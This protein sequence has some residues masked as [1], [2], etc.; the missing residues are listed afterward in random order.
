MLF[1]LNSRGNFPCQAHWFGIP[2]SNT[3][4]S[5]VHSGIERNKR[6]SHKW[7]ITFFHC[8][9]L[10]TRCH[11]STYIAHSVQ[12]RVHVVYGFWKS[13]TWRAQRS[14]LT[15]SSRLRPQR[16]KFI[17][18]KKN[19]KNPMKV[20]ERYSTKWHVGFISCTSF[21][22]SIGCA[23]YLRL[24]PWNGFNGL[25]LIRQV[26]GCTHNNNANNIYDMR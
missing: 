23:I 17:P 11:M 26:S 18:K 20:K 2:P 13:K 7:F 3:M 14:I 8:H 24:N 16:I 12:L 1:L 19:T 15:F 21:V 5:I 22:I 25:H 10:T 4:K 9:G 6:K